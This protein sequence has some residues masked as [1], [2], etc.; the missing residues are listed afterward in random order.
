MVSNGIFVQWDWLSPK[1]NSDFGLSEERVEKAFKEVEFDFISISQP[2]SI[3]PS[4]G[5]MPV[6]MGVAKNA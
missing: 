3:T 4:K 2:F 1:N 5:S 6:L